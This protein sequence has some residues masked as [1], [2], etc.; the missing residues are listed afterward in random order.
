MG[1]STGAL[2]TAASR[3]GITVEEYQAL[4]A[5]GLKWCTPCR[6]W[7]AL[8]QFAKDKSRGDGRSSKCSTHY[9][10]TT[11]G[12]SKRERR[13]Q[14]ALGLRWCRG[15]SHWL[16]TAHVPRQGVCRKC[17]AAEAR[18]RYAGPAGRVIRAQ[19][20]ARKR[21]LDPIPVWWRDEQFDAFRGLCAYG[22]G[23]VA[24]ALDHIW[25]VRRGGRSTPANLVPACTSCNSSK[26]AKDPGPW[27]ERGT[28]AFPE[29]WL[30]VM[31]LALLHGTDEWLET[32]FPELT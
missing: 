12:P 22:C 16:P 17:A 5:Q 7:K 29:E 15:C 26:N 2:K 1:S 4:R 28:A 6:E 9:A 21:G 27:V 3:V 32:T 14:A 19:K 13:Q 18:V 11:P 8:E 25:P 23:S 30:S 31:D 20:N 10:R 24:S